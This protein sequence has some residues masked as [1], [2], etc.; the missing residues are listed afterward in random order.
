LRRKS[1]A[2]PA[3]QRRAED[4]RLRHFPRR[5]CHRA[6]PDPGLRQH[7]ERTRNQLRARQL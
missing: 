7:V 2:R 3:C 1:P 5:R 6:D 4:H